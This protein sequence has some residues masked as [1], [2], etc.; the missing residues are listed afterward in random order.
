M[1]GLC[2]SRILRR[3]ELSKRLGVSEV[4]IWRWERK[5]LLPPKRRFGPNTVGWLASEI[6]VWWAEKIAAEA[7][8]TGR[9][10]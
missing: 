4:T 10:S 9:A 2:N 6:E 3:K 5:G 7:E 8:P 1:A